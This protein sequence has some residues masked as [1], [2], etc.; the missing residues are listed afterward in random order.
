MFPAN[1]G[2]TARSEPMADEPETEDIVVTD[3]QLFDSAISDAP[4][5]P[6]S[7]APAP[8]PSEQ[9]SQQPPM[10]PQM[11]PV[12]DPSRQRDASGRFVKAPPQ[13]QQPQPQQPQQRPP[14]QRPPQ[15]EDHRT[16]P[17]RELLDERDKR[18]RLET[19]VGQMQQAWEYFI[20][21]QRQQLQQ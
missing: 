21:Q 17:L 15:Q 7:E 20:S 6:E 9:P 13:L 16:I 11:Q 5:T 14:Q 1:A 19:Q 8:Q 4:S 2:D 10:Q 3:R 12:V 18:Q